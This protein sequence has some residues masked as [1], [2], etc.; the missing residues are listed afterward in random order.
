MHE[1][2]PAINCHFGDDACVQSRLETA[3]SLGA[4]WVHLDVCDGIF[5]FNKTWGNSK[6][7]KSFSGVSSL[8]LEVHLMVA[9][10]ELVLES[11]LQAGASRVVVHAEA[12]LE[13]SGLD[14][15]MEDGT[16]TEF[17][18]ELCAA[19]E[20]ECMLSS[21]PE[22]PVSFFSPIARSFRF[23]QVL[24][25]APGLAGQ[26]FLSPTLE[27]VRSIMEFN[28][29]AIV[30]VDGGVTDE[31]ARLALSSG[32][33]VLVSASSIFASA[34]PDAAYKKLCAVSPASSARAV[35][36]KRTKKPSSHTKKS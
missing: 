35:V 6:M 12:L 14:R 34:H 17:V 25:V 13:P 15:R 24:T 18:L 26:A 31:T 32:A 3:T 22:T 21:N 10:P 9:R 8:Q 19:Y 27:K 29:K 5:T 16:V 33:S 2:I 1:V 7:W 30:E 23:F 20:A 11:W 4:S 28:P 36:H